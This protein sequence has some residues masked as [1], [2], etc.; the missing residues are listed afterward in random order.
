MPRFHLLI[1]VLLLSAT[2]TG[3]FAQADPN[4]S[5][6]P[7]DPTTM[8]AAQRAQEYQKLQGD[9]TKAFQTGQFRWAEQIC[10]R[11]M[12]LAPTTPEPAYN[13]AC[14]LSQQDRLDEALAAIQRAIQLGWRDTE[15]LAR[16][17]DL[18]ALR[19]QRGQQLAAML[20]S[21]TISPEP[22]VVQRDG[23]KIISAGP[24]N[25]LP[26]RLTMSADA[27][28]AQPQRVVVWLHPAGGSMNEGIEAY[29][30]QLHKAGFALVV[31]TH[32]DFRGWSGQ[33]AAKL[34]VTLTSLSRLE[35]IDIRKPVL[36]GYSAGGQMAL[37]LWLQRPDLW[38]G[39]VLDA[40]YPL[41]LTN[42]GWSPL[43]L[44]EGKDLSQVPILAFVGGADKGL[45]VWN[46]AQEAWKQRQIPL[47]LQVVPGKGHTWLIG[48]EQL[49]HLL[50][51]LGKLPPADQ[52][53]ASEPDS[54]EAQ[55]Q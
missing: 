42:K 5:T 41:Q 27:N 46:Q 51:W 13:L 12:R 36:L 28:A 30:P 19:E 24:T 21:L 48:K 15:H 40:S 22:E 54:P 18:A 49:A 11:Q 47:D 23:M 50:E 38:G 52:P 1:L 34:G 25:G 53:G 33:D 14:A 6:A 35:G 2:A 55:A 29:A 16:D 44:P 17:S 8:S 26:Y 31:F 32:K 10:H 7:A 39:L 37:L 3:S 45:D 43:P 20:Q 9:L 4:A